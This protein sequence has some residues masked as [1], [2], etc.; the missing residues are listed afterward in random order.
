MSTSEIIKIIQNGFSIND[1]CVQVYGYTNGSNIKK[2]KNIIEENNID[3]SHFKIKNKNRKYNIISKK[4]SVCDFIFDVNE[5]DKKTTCSIGCSNTYFRSNKSKE[6]RDKISESLKKYNN[7]N[8]RSSIVY[9]KKCSHCGFEFERKRLKSGNLSK[10]TTCSE[11]CR[12][13]LTSKKLSKSVKER[14]DNGTHNGW[15]SRKIISYPEKF[16]IKVLNNNNIN[17]EFNYPI[18]KRNILGVNEPYNYFLDFYFPKKNMVLEIDGSQHRYRVE[19]DFIRD[20]RLTNAGIKVFRIKWKSINNE[21]GKNYIQ[22]EIN[23][24]LRFY[25]DN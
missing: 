24:F 6:V 3:I 10:S 21:I 25:N 9:N 18:N 8:H 15:Q 20:E 4:C 1:V 17:Y 12:K 2:I 16:F 13:E 14:I 5:N 19:H 11:V 23:R 7:F 22:E